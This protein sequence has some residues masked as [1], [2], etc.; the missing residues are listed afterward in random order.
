[1]TALLLLAAS[2][3]GMQAADLWVSPKGNDSNSGSFEAPKATLR[4]A[5]R[6]AR[7][8]RRLGR[9]LGD[10]IHIWHIPGTYYLDEPILIRPEDSGTKDCPTYIHGT[11]Y[12]QLPRQ[13]DDMEGVQVT[14]SGGMPLKNWK[15][16]SKAPK[17]LRVPAADI[18]YTDVPRT[19]GQQLHFRQFYVNGKKALK[20]CD[21]EDPDRLN[22]IL[23]VDKERQTITIPAPKVRSFTKVDGMEFFIHQMWEVAILRIKAIEIKG[24]QA[25]L[26]FHQPESRL[27]FEHPWPPA[28]IAESGNSP[29]RL[30]GAIELLDQPGEWYYDEH[31]G[32]LYYYASAGQD[33][34][35]AECVVPVLEN[36]IRVEGSLDAPVENI[37][38][39]DLNF[40]HSTWLRPSL[41][42]YV[43]L[44]AGMYLLDAYKLQEP[45][46]P[47]KE[48]LENQA[49]IGRQPAAVS[50]RGA[51]NVSFTDCRF[52]LLGASG[53]D[54]VE[55]CSDSRVYACKFSHIAGSG[56]VAGKFSD[57]GVETHLPYQ[58]QDLREVCSNLHITEN[59]VFDCAS[60]YWGCVGIIAGYVRDFLIEH[61]EVFELPYSGISV[62]WGW[63]RTANVMRDNRI[64]AN[65]VHHF[66]RHNYSCGGI[67]TLSAQTGTVIAENYI[68]DIYHPDYVHDTT[69]GHYIYLDEASS[70]MTIRDN[71]CTEA[72]FGQNQPGLNYWEN[73]GPQAGDWI[74]TKAGRTTGGK[75]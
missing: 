67:Y 18:W 14:I 41:Q 38:F 7:E 45:G 19:G 69:Q 51:R 34:N 33:M 47:L 9:E 25:V 56:L 71:W 30:S 10:A 57:P 23:A 53:L 37:V 8:M 63:I 36:L 54:Y 49:W 27:E 73:N 12:S 1:M 60:E 35:M 16:L 43:P 55:G 11:R 21:I 68:H 20:A 74:R 65:D 3:P 52:S 15:R 29:F 61:N 59:E 6:E 24:T 26:S 22:K 46:T 50:L 31:S 72:K 66:G 48:N 5:L 39:E 17:G 13:S 2:L 64:L 58:P 70:W 75:K 40:R 42:G 32:R 44:Q 4:G 62:G 28:V